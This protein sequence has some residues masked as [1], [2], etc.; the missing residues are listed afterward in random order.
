VASGEKDCGLY[1]VELG[2]IEKII[3]PDR[4]VQRVQVGIDVPEREAVR[5]VWILVPALPKG[6]KR[7]VSGGGRLQGPTAIRSLRL[8]Y[9]WT[10]HNT[11]EEQREGYSTNGL[12]ELVHHGLLPECSRS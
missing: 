6:G 12:T 8:Q 2:L 9:R 7:I 11:A 5:P 4:D 10:R 3:L 1:P